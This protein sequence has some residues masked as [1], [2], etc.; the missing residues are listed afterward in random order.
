MKLKHIRNATMM[1]ELGGARILIDPMLG[2][3]GSIE[4][5]ANSAGNSVRNPTV[6]LV[7]PLEELTGVDVVVVTHTHVDHWDD[8]ATSLLPRQV[9]LLAQNDA[10]AKAIAAHG[11][12]DVQVMAEPIVIGKTS[13]TKTKGQHGSDATLAAWPR[14]GEVSG[15]VVRH[16]G[17]PTVYIA[18]DTV[19]NEQV[20]QALLEHRPDVIVLNTGEARFP[21]NSAL[22]MGAREI[23]EV[24]EAAP[25]ANIVAVHMEA[26]NHCVVTRA[27]ARKIAEDHRISA[28]V[29]VPEDGE[30]LIF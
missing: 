28:Q 22:I 23:L 25:E 16:P 29:F 3:K 6:D 14:L 27:Q 7:V 5:F 21:D 17:E 13:F 20:R 8:A 12:S 30:V 18:G 2:A 15:V 9:P 4:S 11:F 1:L 24:H 19:W 26:L 10:D